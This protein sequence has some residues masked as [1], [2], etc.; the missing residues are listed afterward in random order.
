MWT[1]WTG[2]SNTFDVWLFE[3]FRR[4][5]LTL[6]N[7]EIIETIDKFE[8]EVRALKDQSLRMAWYMRGGLSYDDTMLLSQTER[9]L[10]EKIIKDN[11]ETTQKS[12]M[13]FF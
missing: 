7:D 9:E 5:L 3:F 6:S 13:P 2:L 12:K 11:L 10:V 8:K 1:L 4:W